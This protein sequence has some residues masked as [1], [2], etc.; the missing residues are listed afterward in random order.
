M[1]YDPA[2]KKSYRVLAKEI[3]NLFLNGIKSKSRS[4]PM[5]K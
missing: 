1:W 3:F 4:S 2:K 5:A